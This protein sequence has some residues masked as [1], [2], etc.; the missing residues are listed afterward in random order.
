MNKRQFLR[1]LSITGAAALVPG[2]N[3]RIAPN[4]QLSILG[5]AHAQSLPD[6]YIGTDVR[7]SYLNST[8]PSPIDALIKEAFSSHL[9]IPNPWNIL[10]TRADD[11]SYKFQVMDKRRDITQTAIVSIDGS[12][13]KFAVDES[14]S[15]KKLKQPLIKARILKISP[16][17]MVF[18]AWYKKVGQLNW[19]LVPGDANQFP[20]SE[21]SSG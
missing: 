8:T 9:N 19:T 12:K 1:V 14:R 6:A 5:T 10:A 11:S 21:C 17:E 4:E 20:A 3:R 7:A 18:E 2:L 15:C 13:T 16:D